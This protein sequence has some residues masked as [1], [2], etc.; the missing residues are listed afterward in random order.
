MDV[1]CSPWSSH[2]AWFGG[3]GLAIAHSKAAEA[4]QLPLY[5]L[6]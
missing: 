1:L 6:L 3:A 4:V 2:G 5:F